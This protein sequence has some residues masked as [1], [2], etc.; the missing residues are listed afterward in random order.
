M[1]GT[2]FHAPTFEKIEYVG[3]DGNN[4]YEV[5]PVRG[6]SDVV[7][8]SSWNEIVG[9]CVRLG[10]PPDCWPTFPD[11]Y[12]IPLQLVQ[13]KSFLLRAK[14]DRALDAELASLPWL[15]TVVT[16]LRNGE[17]IFYAEE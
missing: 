9:H 7:S 16:Y 17:Q 3:N 2:L 8:I 10:I 11:A 15:N 12:D 14:L 4:H 5:I 13:E 6:G 1:A